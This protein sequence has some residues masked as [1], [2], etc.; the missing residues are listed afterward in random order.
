MS[1]SAG[2]THFVPETPLPGLTLTLGPYQ[3]QSITVDSVT[4]SLYTHR[5]HNY[6][7]PHFDVIADT[8]DAVIAELRQDLEN[9]LELD[10]PFRR[11]TLVETPI[12]FVS[13]PHLW[14]SHQATVQPEMV[15]LPE[16]GMGLEW[17][18]F[19]QAKRRERETGRAVQP[20][21]DA[22]GIASQHVAAVCQQHPCQHRGLAPAR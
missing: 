9:Q 16:N 18:D 4:Y 20:G 3:S 19:K 2:V 7:K 13:Y 8:L 14:S 22:G 12:H 5:D 15:L 6:W 21:G 11:L 10:Y 1:D 17:A